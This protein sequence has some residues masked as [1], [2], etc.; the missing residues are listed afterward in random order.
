MNMNEY[1]IYHLIDPRTETPFYVGKGKNKR[2]YYHEKCVKRG[3]IPNKNKHLFYKIKQILNEN[4][5]VKYIK[6]YENLTE[7]D[8]WKKEIEEEQRLK[9]NG[10]V[11]CNL[12]PCGCG[13][14]TLSNHPN[15]VD[16]YRR[17]SEHR[18]KTLA[19]E[20]KKNIGLG[21]LGKKHSIESREKR[22]EKFK[23]EKNPMFG[24]SVPDDVKQKISKSLSGRIVSPETRAR[25]KL[26]NLGRVRSEETRKKISIA[27]T[28]IKLSDE[29]RKNIS[30]GHM[31]LIK[32]DETRRKLSISNTGKKRSDE[33]KRKLSEL[34]S[35][36][37]GEKNSNFRPLSIESDAFILANPN[38][39][40][41]WIL[42]HLPEKVSYN[43][44]KRRITEL[45]TSISGLE[46]VGS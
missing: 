31:G 4:L 18:P 42:T 5:S 22:S 1:Y 13:G 28:G 30:L 10:I 23:G 32:S 25:L 12:V 41:Y 6:I 15:K 3:I 2:M 33:T 46:K 38:E 34:A 27:K 37:T 9:Q 8:A 36:R 24:K 11:L 29:V 14:D 35:V 20:W 16:I 39:S 17:M 45:K 7:P 26:V 40:V 19:D 44:V 21:L 43:R